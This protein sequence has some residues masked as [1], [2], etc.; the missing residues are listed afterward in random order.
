MRLKELHIC[1]LAAFLVLFVAAGSG[2][3]TLRVAPT[4]LDL[5]APDSASV[6]QLRNEASRP[7]HVQ[8]RVFRW[9]QGR[10]GETLVPTEAVVASP[11]ATRLEPGMNYTIRVVRTLKVPVRGEESYRVIVDELPDPARRRAGTVNL[12]VRHSI[13]V[14]F[15]A[16][17]AAP[18][19]IS[20]SLARADGQLHLVARNVGGSRLRLSDALLTD[21]GRPVAHAKGLL[22]YVLPGAVMRWPLV[23]LS[24]AGKGPY[25]LNVQSHVGPIEAAVSVEPR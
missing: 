24:K 23:P 1:L 25:R 6:L 20:W 16:P 11:P 18:A 17:D 22:G 10:N 4:V 7:L 13:P 12:V 8:I 14:F 9:R 3:A 2:A 21:R 15:R 5:V 19:S